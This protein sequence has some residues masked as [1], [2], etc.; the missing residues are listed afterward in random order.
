[1]EIT[2]ANVTTR[3][4]RGMLGGALGASAMTIVRLTA[5]RLG[6]VEAMVPQSAEARVTEASGVEPP[7]G[8]IGHHATAEVLGLAAVDA[9]RRA[10]ARPRAF[11]VASARVRQRGQRGVAPDL[12]SGD[13]ARGGGADEADVATGDVA[14][15]GVRCPPTEAACRPGAAAVWLP[16]RR[17]AVG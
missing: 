17:I 5:R 15:G 16:P 4:V 10:R 11:P 8:R 6:L 12:R 9:R 13:R 3:I 1:M 14:Q 2:G 7:G